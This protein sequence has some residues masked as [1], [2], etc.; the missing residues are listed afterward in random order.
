[1]SEW[2]IKIHARLYF[3]TPYGDECALMYTQIF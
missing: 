3:T 1:M 2:F